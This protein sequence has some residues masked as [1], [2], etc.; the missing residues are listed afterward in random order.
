MTYWLNLVPIITEVFGFELKLASAIL[1]GLLIGLERELLRKPA[2]LRTCAMVCMGSMLFTHLSYIV[3]V[4]VANAFTSPISDVT[5]I[6]SVVVQGIGF[7]GGG[8]IIFFKDKLLGLTTAAVIWGVAAIG[9]AIGF[10]HF[11][12]AFSVTAMTLAILFGFGRIEKR[13]LKKTP[14]KFN[15]Y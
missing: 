12:E 14:R 7:I 10:N 4:E 11:S 3:S 13:F 9:M 15:A 8:A 2:G 1:C 6:A 5:R